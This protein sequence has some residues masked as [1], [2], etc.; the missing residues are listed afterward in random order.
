MDSGSFSPE[1]DGTCGRYPARYIELVYVR[2]RA[3]LPLAPGEQEVERADTVPPVHVRSARWQTDDAFRMR[4]ITQLTNKRGEVTGFRPMIQRGHGAAGKRYHAPFRASEF[5]GSIDEA[6]RQAQLWRDNTEAK[7]GIQPGSLR[8]RPESL[9][10]NGISLIV[11]KT[12]GG[13]AY[14]GSNRLQDKPMLRSYIGQ[15]SYVEAYH[16]LILKVAERDGIPVPDE[17]PMPPPPRR[18]QYR[19]LK[20]A[21]I[22]DIPEPA[23]KR[24]KRIG[25]TPKSVRPV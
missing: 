19:R 7:L 1:D 8:S 24:A 23:R 16:A 2:R 12:A 4:R 3:Y 18:E 14:W 21:G 20:K 6:L 15:K 13:R 9:P 5:N 11:S 22:T 17:L 25:T 10:W